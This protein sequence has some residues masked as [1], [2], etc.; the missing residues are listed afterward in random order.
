MLGEVL[1]ETSETFPR[2]TAQ[3]PPLI[4]TSNPAINDAAETRV[5]YFVGS[6]VCKSVWILVRQLR[7]PHLSTWA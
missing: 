4:D 1:F 7:G 5:F 6:S 2:W 3:I